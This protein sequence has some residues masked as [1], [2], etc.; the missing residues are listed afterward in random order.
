MRSDEVQRPA[1]DARQRRLVT[2][3]DVGVSRRSASPTG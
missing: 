2:E 3:L 1:D